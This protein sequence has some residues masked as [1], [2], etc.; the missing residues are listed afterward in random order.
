LTK[1]RNSVHRFWINLPDRPDPNACWI[2]K[3]LLDK[4]GY[5]VYG[6]PKKWGTRRAHRVAYMLLVGPIPDGLQIDHVKER[7]CTSR[8]CCNPAHLEPVTNR[9]NTLRGN[10]IPANNIQ[11]T[12]CP[13]G[14]PYAGDNLRFGKNGDRICKECHRSVYYTP[15]PKPKATHCKHG[16]EYTEENTH[17]KKCGERVCRTCGRERMQKRRARTPVRIT[18]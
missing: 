3:G 12:H 11:K 2:W 16:H 7:G 18:S 17:V 9:T 14:H 5:G 1:T 13:Q 4:D 10:T 6:N 8:A 15:H